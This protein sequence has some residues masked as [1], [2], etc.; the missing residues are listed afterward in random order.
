MQCQPIRLAH[1]SVGG[2]PCQLGVRVRNAIG[3]RY[4]E[5]G[6]SGIDVPGEERQVFVTFEQQL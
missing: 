3:A 5:P 4:V 2:R 1:A 6:F